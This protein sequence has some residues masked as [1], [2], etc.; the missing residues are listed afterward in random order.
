MT[1]EPTHHPETRSRR[2]DHLK[3]EMVKLTS[4]RSTY[5]VSALGLLLSLAMCAMTTWGLT[6][7]MATTSMEELTPL[8]LRTAVPALIVV[9]VVAVVAVTACRDDIDNGTFAYSVLRVASKRDAWLGKMVVVIGLAAL[10]GVVVAL[11]DLTLMRLMQPDLDGAS[12]GTWLG[13]P[14]AFGAVAAGWASMGL[15]LAAFLPTTGTAVVGVLALPLIIE[16]AVTSAL[17]DSLVKDF[18]PFGAGL[19]LLGG[20]GGTVADRQLP[21]AASGAVFVLFLLV[22]AWSGIL[23]VRTLDV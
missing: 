7:S 21:M 11:A 13:A 22:T 4:L 12:V 16:P 10:Y 2:R 3:H 1:H 5:I 14:V 20:E 23:R 18:L 19:A 8:V 6:E 15:A 17:G 9:A